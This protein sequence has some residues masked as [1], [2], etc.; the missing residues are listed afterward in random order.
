MR[1][2]SGILTIVLVLL[3]SPYGAFA[4]EIQSTVEGL[5]IAFSTPWLSRVDSKPVP[6]GQTMHSWTRAAVVAGRMTASPG[7]TM[8][9]TPVQKDADLTP[10]SQGILARPP[11]S[12]RLGV[13]TLCIK[14]V[15][16]RIRQDGKTISAI[17][18]TPPPNCQMG[19][20]DSGVNCSYQSVNYI[21]L[22]LEPSWANRYERDAP[23]GKMYVLVIHL[24]ESGRLVDFSF[25][26][27]KDSAPTIEPEIKAIMS[28]V[29]LHQ[30]RIKTGKTEMVVVAG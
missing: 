7:L 28:S 12:V 30:T 15:S 25:A 1:R 5:D 29:R 13:D 14:C 11:H 22:M 16:Y 6:T 8:I 9:S 26:Y 10:I 21:G 2:I 20:A 4:G 3:L 24:L 19:D 17:S 27:P 18:A 23:F